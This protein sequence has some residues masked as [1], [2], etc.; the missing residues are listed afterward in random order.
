M[1]GF[2]FPSEIFLGTSRLQQPREPQAGGKHLLTGEGDLPGRN[3]LYVCLTL[4]NLPPPHSLAIIRALSGNLE[5]ATFYV[6]VVIYFFFSCQV[7]DCLRD[8]H[9][10]Y[11]SLAWKKPVVPFAELTQCGS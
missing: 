3:G 8:S 1:G 10:K 5:P 7:F 2:P 9:G 4:L 6:Y 11:L